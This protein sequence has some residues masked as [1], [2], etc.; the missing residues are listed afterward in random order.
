MFTGGSL[1]K[2]EERCYPPSHLKGNHWINEE[3]TYRSAFPILNTQLSFKISQSPSKTTFCITEELQATFSSSRMT[4][5]KQGLW[6][7][8]LVNSVCLHPKALLS[9]TQ[10]WP[11]RGKAP[12]GSTGLFQFQ[13]TALAFPYPSP[14]LWRGSVCIHHRQA[15]QC[16]SSLH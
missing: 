16:P 3:L 5:P 7:I 4:H 1:V 12:E 2:W 13:P 15:W 6:D 11:A 8:F 10:N 9:N 14:H